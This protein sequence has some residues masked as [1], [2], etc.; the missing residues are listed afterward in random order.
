MNALNSNPVFNFQIAFILVALTYSVTP[1]GYGP[2]RY[3]TGT[4]V[5]GVGGTASLG[6]MGNYAGRVGGSANVG[7]TGRRVHLG[8]MGRFPRVAGTFP[9]GVG[10]SAPF[11][12]SRGG[13]VGLGTVTQPGVFGR[14]AGYGVSTQ[15]FKLQEEFSKIFVQIN[16]LQKNIRFM[17]SKSVHAS[18]FIEVYVKHFSQ[19]FDIEKVKQVLNDKISLFEPFT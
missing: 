8:G 16:F 10:G 18:N 3:T 9:G 12:G 14:L 2:G 7:G 15:C 17:L 19:S 5:G 4:T 11:V 6:G 13:V 1:K